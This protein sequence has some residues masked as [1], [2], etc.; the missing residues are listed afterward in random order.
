MKGTAALVGMRHLGERTAVDK[1]RETG[2]VAPRQNTAC[3][4]AG[5]EI[6]GWPLAN[7][8]GLP[9]VVGR[10]GRLHVLSGVYIERLN[11]KRFSLRTTSARSWSSMP[12]Q[13][14]LKTLQVL[15][16][17]LVVRFGEQVVAGCLA[18]LIPPVVTTKQQPRLAKCLGPRSS[19]ISFMCPF[20]GCLCFFGREGSTFHIPHD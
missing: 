16:S 5:F 17:M 6:S 8:K 11:K 1:G 12:C 3:D 10:E 15:H 9:A 18:S 13:R 14:S 7:K 19:T 4:T 2:V 20:D